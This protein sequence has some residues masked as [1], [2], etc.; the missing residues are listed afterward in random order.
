MGFVERIKS[1]VEGIEDSQVKYIVESL[2]SK[3]EDFDGIY[4]DMQNRSSTA[5]RWKYNKI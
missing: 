1:E 3:V 2:F 4:I 5:N